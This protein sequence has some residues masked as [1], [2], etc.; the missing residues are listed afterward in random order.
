MELIDKVEFVFE[1][2]PEGGFYAT[3]RTFP[4]CTLR[5]RVSRKPS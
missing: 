2:Q 4:G 3:L 5:A 1:N